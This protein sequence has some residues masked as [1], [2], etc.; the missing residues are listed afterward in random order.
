MHA[1]LL[2]GRR[3][4]ASLAAS[5]GRGPRPGVSPPPGRV[6]ITPSGRPRGPA[7]PR[8]RAQPVPTTIQRQGC[9]ATL[10]LRRHRGP[11]DPAWIPPR[12]PGWLGSPSAAGQRLLAGTARLPP[13]CGAAVRS[14]VGH[15]PFTRSAARSSVDHPPLRGAAAAEHR[16]P[17]GDTAAR[18]AAT[19]SPG[20]GR[21]PLAPRRAPISSDSL[22]TLSARRARTRRQTSPPHRRGATLAGARAATTGKDDG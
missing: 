18:H 9:T 16:I 14:P 15:R 10:H 13:W 20:L 1:S 3:R 2:A 22:Q 5:H 8:R 4:P 6:S 11:G 12:Q 21:E 17:T 19:P 7:R